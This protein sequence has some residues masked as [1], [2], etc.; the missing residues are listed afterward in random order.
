ME[1]E[2][3]RDYCKILKCVPNVP[4]NSDDELIQTTKVSRD[5]ALSHGDRLVVCIDIPRD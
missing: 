1:A 4:E 3:S 2:V 5:R